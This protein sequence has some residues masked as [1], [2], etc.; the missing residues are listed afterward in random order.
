MKRA[1]VTG[2]YGFIGGYLVEEL[3]RR[4]YTVTILD[5]DFPRGIHDSFPHKAEFVKCDLR[6][7]IELNALEYDVVFHCAG[8]SGN[9]A[10]IEKAKDVLEVN[11][12][13]TVG[14]LDW[15]TVNSDIIVVHLNPLGGGLNLNT[16]SKRCAEQ[17]GLIYDDERG[18]RYLSVRLS[19]A[20]GPRQKSALGQ[21]L[22][23]FIEKAFHSLELPV[24]GD[25]SSWVNYVY[26][27]D[28]AKFLVDAYE[29]GARGTPIDFCRPGGDLNILEVA[30][31]IIRL[32]QSSSQLKFLPKRP[33]RLDGRK[34]VAYDLS[35]AR[36][37]TDMNTLTDFD[38]GLKETIRWFRASVMD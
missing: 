15:A 1:I 18:L 27:E 24:Y 28:V 33:G 36:E 17:I 31:T 30:G 14:L 13:A 34:A 4:Q 5:I 20:Y 23:L 26:V 21:L 22:P 2:G 6:Y 16:V 29:S 11:V 37:I 35:G 38:W 10:R 25:G 12:L 3:E 9:A 19:N 32:M 7:G 8:L